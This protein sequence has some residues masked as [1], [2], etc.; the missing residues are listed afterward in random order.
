MKEVISKARK[1]SL[2]PRKI[3]V[4]NISEEKQIN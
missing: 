4:G 3:I 2:L 1:Q